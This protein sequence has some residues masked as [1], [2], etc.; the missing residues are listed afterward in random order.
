MAA[1]RLSQGAHEFCTSAQID[2]MPLN[3]RAG[4]YDDNY[5]LSQYVIMAITVYYHGDII[6]NFSNYIFAGL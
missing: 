5:H 3:P 2:T 6:K 4:R 1:C